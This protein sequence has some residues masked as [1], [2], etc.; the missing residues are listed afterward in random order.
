[1]TNGKKS[2]RLVIIVATNK[3]MKIEAPN[4][5]APFIMALAFWSRKCGV[6]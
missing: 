3:S 4:R 5:R 1:M 6:F 2:S